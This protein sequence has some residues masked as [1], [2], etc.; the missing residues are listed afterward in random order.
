M[1]VRYTCDVGGYLLRRT[2]KPAMV[3][4]IKGLGHTI[5][6]GALPRMDIALSI[7]VTFLLTLVNG[8]FSMSE[9]HV[10]LKLRIQQCQ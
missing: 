8:F 4:I 3:G 6:E 5:E 10:K 7:A 9:I 1:V 2:R